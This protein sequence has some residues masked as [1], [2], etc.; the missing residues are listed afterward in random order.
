MRPTGFLSVPKVLDAFQRLVGAQASKQRFVESE[1]RA[2]S[3][4]R[5][6]NLGCGTGALLEHLPAGTHYLGVDVSP[7]YIRAARDR[8]GRA[9]SFVCADV[10]SFRP[11]QDEPFD[12]V[13]AYGLFHHLDDAQVERAFAVARS[14][15]HRSGRLVAAEP[16]ATPRR[17][18]LESLLMALDRGA[19]IRA[20][21]EYAS[22]AEYAFPEVKVRIARGELRIPYTFAVLEARPTS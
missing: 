20:P 11:E 5:V 17:T 14:A 22:L 10:T 9:G 6:L 2:S 21:A 4:M 16:C 1:V 13:I 8:H 19:F 15:L 12:V 3:G 18:A 7:E